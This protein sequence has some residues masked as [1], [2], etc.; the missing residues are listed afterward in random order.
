M[1]LRVLSSAWRGVS[2]SA[3]IRLSGYKRGF[4]TTVSV[5][6]VL[7]SRSLSEADKMYSIA[8][9][10]VEGRSVYLDAQATTRMDPRVVDA[11]LP[12]MTEAFGNPHS[13]THEYGWVAESAVEK[14]I[15][16]IQNNLG[17]L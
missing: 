12:F 8:E 11:M 16:G 13:R 14:V 5:E 7:Q 10:T 6:D 15:F 4:S 17:K 9:Q 2:R 3:T 1:S